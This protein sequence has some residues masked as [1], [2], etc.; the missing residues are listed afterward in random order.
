ML[1]QRKKKTPKKTKSK[2]IIV[3]DN[4]SPAGL[5]L[6][7]QAEGIEYEIQ[8]GLEGE[9]LREALLNFDGAVCRSGVTITEAALADNKRLKAIVR[10]GVGTDN[11]DK[12]AATRAGIVVMNTPTGNTVSTAEHAMALLLG[13]SRNVAPAHASLVAGK[14]DRKKFSGSELR[15][16]TLGIVGLGRIGQTVA[17]KATAFDMNIVGYDPFLSESRAEKMGIK[18]YDKVDDMLPSC[19]YLTVH[20]PLT[21][22]TKGL[23]GPCTSSAP[24]ERC[25]TDQLRPRRNLR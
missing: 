9:G 23:I 16:K 5:A 24:E 22:E 8:V 20:T 4:L 11:I 25:E 21:P 2:R 14:W 13:L 19:D 1:D 7:E 17:E 15:G 10:A 18:L 12:R 6:L 3:L